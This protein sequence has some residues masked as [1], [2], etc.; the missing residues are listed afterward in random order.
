M[1]V[2]PLNHWERTF[3]VYLSADNEQ[4]KRYEQKGKDWPLAH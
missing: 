2:R 3:S 1:N 4:R